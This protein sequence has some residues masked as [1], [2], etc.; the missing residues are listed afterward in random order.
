[1]NESDI[2]Y[3][4]NQLEIKNPEF[5]DVPLNDDG[6]FRQKKVASLFDSVLDMVVEICGDDMPAIIDLRSDLQKA[7]YHAKLSLAQN[8]KFRLRRNSQ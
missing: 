7:F 8:Q 2:D 4:L 6:L 3:L 1:M 5:I